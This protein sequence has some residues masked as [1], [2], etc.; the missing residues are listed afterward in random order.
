MRADKICK[1][2][3]I[4]LPTMLNENILYNEDH[5]IAICVPCKKGLPDDTRQHFQRNHKDI[6]LATR[7]IIIEQVENLPR[8]PAENVESPLEEMDAIEGIE[9]IPGF[10]CIADD[11]CNEVSGKLSSI[12]AHCRD[13]HGWNK[14]LRKIFIFRST[15][16]IACQW[17]SQKIQTIFAEPNVKY[18]PVRESS[19]NSSSSNQMDAFFDNMVAA[20]KRKDDDY[21]LQRHKIINDESTKDTPW[22]NRTDWKRMYAGKDMS[23]LVPATDEQ[24]SPGEES[25]KC[26]RNI[27]HDMIE[28]DYQDFR[29]I[30]HY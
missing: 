25:F 26:L 18:F 19:S 22:L 12:Q 7:R 11:M 20:A 9:I 5:Q 23:D 13:K 14:K 17:I 4:Y 21:R 16:H 30:L 29:L 28:E 27:I 8:L 10:K 15:H 24:L 2:Y 1:P 6:S 3:R